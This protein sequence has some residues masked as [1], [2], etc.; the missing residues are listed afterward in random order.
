MKKLVTLI[1]VLCSS[2]LMDCSCG[3]DDG[4]IILPPIDP[5]IECTT[6]EDCLKNIEGCFTGLCITGECHF[7]YFVNGTPCD[8]ANPCTTHGECFKGNCIR[9]EFIKCIPPDQC[10]E[11][12]KC[13]VLTGDCLYLNKIDGSPCNDDNPCTLIDQCYD[14]QC[15][16]LQ[17][18]ECPEINP[19]LLNGICNKTTGD[20]EYSCKLDGTP[21][22][23]GI[24]CNG[25]ES[26]Q[27]GICVDGD[28]PCSGP[29][30]EIHKHCP[31]ECAI[32]ADCDNGIDCDGKEWCCTLEKTDWG[33]E[34]YYCY[35]GFSP[36][37]QPIWGVFT[38]CDCDWDEPC[39]DACRPCQE[40]CECNDGIYCN[41]MER[42]GT[43]AEGNHWGICLHAVGSRPCPNSL[44]NEEK[45]MCAPECISDRDC[46]SEQWCDLNGKCQSY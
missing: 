14:G 20:C 1:G 42:C 22:D 6:N 8:D 40:D 27:D 34:K 37:G 21:C 10:Q 32:D 17:K 24:W 16:S 2:L 39:N 45:R 30:D 38:V 19:C 7:G 5:P 31:A 25:M 41:G 23:D 3:K 18:K 43:E 9:G 36:C 28:P 12:G 11:E 46:S 29:C 26:C 4:I 33:C 35:D 13:N 15:V 44:C